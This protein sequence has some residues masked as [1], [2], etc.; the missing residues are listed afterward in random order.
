MIL[1]YVSRLKKKILSYF[2]LLS[3]THTNYLSQKRQHFA[4]F[5]LAIFLKAATLCSLLLNYLLESGN[6]LLSSFPC[7]PPKQRSLFSLLVSHS[8]FSLP[9]GRTLGPKP[10]NSLQHCLFIRLFYYSFLNQEYITSLIRNR[11]PSTSKNSL[12]FYSKET[13]INFL[14]RKSN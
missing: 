7:V 8:I 1:V 12:S 6:I 10:S 13:Q 2:S 5:S 4:L 9:I 14:T 11:L 3:H